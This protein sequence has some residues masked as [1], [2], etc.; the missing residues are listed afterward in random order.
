[1]ITAILLALL[2]VSPA[3]AQQQP[4]G[5]E[6]TIEARLDEEADQ[7]EGR[8]RLRYTNNA[9]EALDT[10]WV[11]QHLNAFRPNSAWA[12]RELE[13]GERR[14]TDLGPEEHAYER[15]RRITVNGSE[16]RAHYPLS[17]DSTVAGIPL[18]S[19]LSPGGTVEVVMDWEARPSTEPRRQARRGRQYDFAQWHPRIAV[20]DEEG[21]HEHP[22]LPQGEFFG[23]FGSYEV[24]LD[25][26]DDQIVGATGIPVEGDPG[27]EAVARPGYDDVHYRRDYY[28]DVGPTPTLGF[29]GESPGEGRKRIRWRAEAVHHFAWSTAPHFVYEGTMEDGVAFHVLYQQDAADEWGN[30]VAL[31]RTLR[32]R[33]FGDSIFGRYGYPQVTN[34]H[35]IESGGT[36]FPMLVMDGSASEGLIVHEMIHMYIHAILAPNEWREAWFDEG[37]TTF[38]TQWYWEVQGMDPEEVWRGRIEGIRERERRG[39]TEPVGLESAEFSDFQMYVQMSYS[40]A[41]LIYRMLRWMV[42]EDTM[43]AILNHLYEENTLSHVDESDLRRSVNT[44]TG[45]SY[46]WFFDQWLYTTDTVDYGIADA[47]T[48]PTGDGRWRTTVRVRRLGNAWMPVALRVGDVERRLDSRDRVQTVE[49]VTDQRP[50]EA[51]LDPD[52]ILVTPDAS[53]HRREIRRAG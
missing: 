36:E 53:N 30:G 24:I 34:L 47:V 42:G 29:L 19:R 23:E 22:L 51:V 17:P 25:L 38:V 16:V 52:D 21:W 45:E 4:Q 13:F 7:L 26:A 18:P 43:V 27:W 49:I 5:V 1:M 46:D 39:Q 32:A 44:V 6:Y 40:K 11:H 14:F 50:S 10:L 33:E 9:P 8:A 48:A 3:H 20:Y 31:E 15:F 41:A 35:R 28:G 2:G 12:Q 37:L